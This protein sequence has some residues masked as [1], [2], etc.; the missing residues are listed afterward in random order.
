MESSSWGLQ[1]GW[2]FS[3]APVS[4]P[5]DGSVWR[6]AGEQQL[7]G[8]HRSSEPWSWYRLVLGPCVDE[9]SPAIF[10]PGQFHRQ[11]G[12][13][14]GVNPFIGRAE[15]WRW[16]AMSKEHTRG[17]ESGRAEALWAVMVW[18][19]GRGGGGQ[20]RVVHWTCWRTNWAHSPSPSCLLLSVSGLEPSYFPHSSPHIP[21][22]VLLE[23]KS[24]THTTLVC[25]VLLS[26]D[27]RRAVLG[28]VQQVFIKMQWK[29]M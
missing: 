24:Q 27:M 23:S 22:I 26:R 4:S 1:P 13:V 5:D 11:A 8:W 6:D 25:R 17:V 9:A 10:S 29:A 19:P 21:H 2:T 18:K 3:T 15:L 12:D 16:G 20:M 14:E 28:L 7:A